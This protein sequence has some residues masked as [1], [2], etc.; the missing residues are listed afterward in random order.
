MSLYKN[1]LEQVKK[2]SKIIQLDPNIE[3]FLCCPKRIIEMNIPVKMDNGKTQIFKGYRVQHNDLAGPFKGGIRYSPMVNMDEVTALASWMTFKCAV[4]G[5]P[6]GGGK[7]G[8]NVDS[9]KLSKKELECLTRA[10][11]RALEPVIGPD[12]DV[13]APDMY[14]D[15]TVMAWIADEYSKLKGKKVPGVVTGKPVSK[16]GS[17]GRDKSTA[18]GGIYVLNEMV[19]EY[20]LRPAETTVVIQ[21]FGNVGIHIAEFLYE[22]GFKI[23]SISDSKGALYCKGGIIAKK[24]IECKSKTGAVK[25]CS[26]ARVDY[27]S[28]DCSACRVVTN[29]KL[30]E[31][32]C[33]ILVLAALE[34]QITNKNAAKIKAKYILELANGPVSPEADKIFSRKKVVVVPDILANAGGVTVSYFEMVQNKNNR[35]WTLKTVNSRLRNVMQEAWKNVLTTSKKYKCTL[36]EAA[37]IAALLRLERLI[38]KK[39]AI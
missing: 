11:T 29:E 21:G 24:A 2:A 18:L 38:E 19:K 23:I 13:P 33:D 6:L 39:K 15:S 7:G 32:D 1:V 17:F 22:Q 10:Y 4:M 26:S 5:L 28:R 36:R 8:I 3:K 25:K 35:Y 27:K 34:N 20:K 31:L 30:L 9:E 14:T 12:L 37:Y 16:G